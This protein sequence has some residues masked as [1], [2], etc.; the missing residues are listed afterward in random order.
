MDGLFNKKMQDILALQLMKERG[1]QPWVGP[2]LKATEA[3]K[4]LIELARK[5]KFWLYL[6]ILFQL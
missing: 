3:E 1:I 2:G 5:Q 4:T 6:K